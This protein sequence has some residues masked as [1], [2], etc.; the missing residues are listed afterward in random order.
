[1]LSFG[2]ALALVP[3]LIFTSDGKL[4]GDLVNTRWV[5]QVGWV[6][7]VL[8]VALNIWLLV[9]TALGFVKQKARWP[10]V[11]LMMM[12]VAT[13][14]TAVVVTIVPAFTITTLISFAFVPA[15]MVAVVM[16]PPAIFAPLIVMVPVI[17]VAPAA[18]I[19]V[20]TVVIAI[21]NL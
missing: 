9:G 16:T 12:F 6:I 21:A 3:L 20:V 14:A 4:M 19:P 7:V 10:F 1:M 11:T 13:P 8:V 18:A 5:K 2:I 15:T 17:P